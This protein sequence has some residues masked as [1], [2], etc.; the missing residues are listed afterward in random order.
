[1]GNDKEVNFNKP[2]M[3]ESALSAVSARPLMMTIVGWAGSQRF[4]MAWTGDQ[5]GSLEWL[6]WHIPTFTTA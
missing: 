4:S 2:V 1:M 6:K 3:I 5:M